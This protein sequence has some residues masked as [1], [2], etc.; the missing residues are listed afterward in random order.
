MSIPQYSY[1][2]HVLKMD[3]SEALDTLRNDTKIVYADPPYTRDHYSRFYHVLETL[4]L[5]DNPNISTMV[6]N[7]EKQISRGIYREYRHQSPFCIKSQAPRAFETL[8]Q[9]VR[10]IDAAL[11]ISYSPYDETKNS[12]SRTVTI[13]DIKKIAYRYYPKIEIL[14]VGSFKHS[15]LTNVSKHLDA[16]KEAEVLIVCKI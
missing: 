7:G 13:R 3:Y 5:R 4:C 12:H 8:I 16:S 2:N 9:K 10:K 14:S 6:T 15:K 11:V 1:T